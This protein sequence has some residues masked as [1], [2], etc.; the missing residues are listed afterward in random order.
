MFP[1]WTQHKLWVIVKVYVKPELYGSLDITVTVAGSLGEISWLILSHK[2]SPTNR[3]DIV[4]G[5]R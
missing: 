1:D 5:V 3:R 2:T 4:S